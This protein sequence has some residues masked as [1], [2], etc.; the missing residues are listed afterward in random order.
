MAVAGN[1][2]KSL[3]WNGDGVFRRHRDLPGLRPAEQARFLQHL[4]VQPLA[5]DPARRYGVSGGQ[6]ELGGTCDRLQ[7][8]AMI[9]SVP[10]A[11]CHCRRYFLG[12]I[13]SVFSQA[14]VLMVLPLARARTY[15]S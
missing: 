14:F 1:E 9:R 10:H 3:S 11:S 6:L 13:S 12:T 5:E 7:G 8:G 15:S 4:L 2:R